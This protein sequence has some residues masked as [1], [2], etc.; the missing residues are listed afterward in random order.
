MNFIFALSKNMNIVLIVTCKISKRMTI[1]SSKFIWTILNWAETLLDRLLITN[2]DIS[3][4]IILNRNSKFISD[5]WKALLSKLDTKLLMSTAYH[6]QTD[7]QSKRTNQIVEIALRFFLIEN[8]N[9]NW[10]SATSLIQANLNNFFNVAIE[11]SFNEI[12]YWKEI[13]WDSDSAMIE[14]TI[15]E[16]KIAEQERKRT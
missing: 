10:I 9:A 14:T 16:W 3:E 7:K 8:S 15:D 6:S 5:F 13:V 1:I 11:L 2:W 12:T 4:E